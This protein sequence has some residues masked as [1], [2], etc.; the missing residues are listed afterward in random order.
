MSTLSD[1]RQRQ[2]IVW[3]TIKRHESRSG[4][5]PTSSLANNMTEV[6]FV[7]Q[8][9]DYIKALHTLNTSLSRSN[10]LVVAASGRPFIFEYFAASEFMAKESQSLLQSITFDIRET[11]ESKANFEE[12]DAFSR[13]ALR[14]EYS[15]SKSNENGHV[16][17]A[18]LGTI[19]MKGYGSPRAGEEI[20]HL[21][22]I[23]EGHQWLQIV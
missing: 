12:V 22:A 9:A 21:L 23:D 18:S 4:E 10:A 7:G 3:N 14:A 16:L 6:A 17:R 20:F 13:S 15:V 2:T 1:F 8:I 11:I 5:R 19:S